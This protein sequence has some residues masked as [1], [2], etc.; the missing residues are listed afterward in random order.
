[1]I[2]PKTYYEV[3]CDCC[4][5]R[6]CDPDDEPCYDKNFYDG[7]IAGANYALSHQWVSVEDAL[8]EDDE[9]VVLVYAYDPLSGSPYFDLATLDGEWYSTSGAAIEVIKWTSIPPL[10]SR[11]IKP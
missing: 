3:H 8:P 9:D 5:E 11:K 1:M 10:P 2:I 7:F 4:G 6:L